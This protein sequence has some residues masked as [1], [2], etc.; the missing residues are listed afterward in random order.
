[1][2]ADQRIFGEIYD[3]S[4]S[5]RITLVYDETS[6]GG[7]DF[8]RIDW[9]TLRDNE[10]R[11]HHTLSQ[12]A[13]SKNSNEQIWVSDIH[14]FDPETANCILKIAEGEKQLDVGH[15]SYIYSWRIWDIKDNKEVKL[16]K[17]CENIWEG[18][19]LLEKVEHTE[20]AS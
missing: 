8:L 3:E 5:H 10:W 6:R 17:V 2:K 19:I 11:I 1:M 13:F 9:H 20:H 7:Y 15:I 4:K 18:P 16:I 12:D 14:S